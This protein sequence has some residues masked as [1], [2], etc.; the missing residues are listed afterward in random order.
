[1]C[2]YSDEIK[3]NDLEKHKVI[4][5][6]EVLK[7]RLIEKEVYLDKMNRTWYTN[8]FQ[9]AKI[10]REAK[11]LQTSTTRTYCRPLSIDEITFN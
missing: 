4:N 10:Q 9:Q 3:L 7:H 8:C 6:I 5:E 1:M 11:N 2:K